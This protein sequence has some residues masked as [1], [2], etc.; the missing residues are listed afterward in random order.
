MAE[1]APPKR[2]GLGEEFWLPLCGRPLPAKNTPEGVRAMAGTAPI[3]PAPVQTYLEKKF[4]AQLAGVCAAMRALAQ[5]FGPAEL[6]DRA[7][8]LYEAFRPEIPRGTAGWGAK[9][10]LRL[11]LL[12][13]LATRD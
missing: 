1:G 5:A 8:G 2:R 12:R 11:D 9:G 13:S 3:E 4:G 10:E 6:E 7:Y